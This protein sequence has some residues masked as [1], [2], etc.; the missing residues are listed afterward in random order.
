MVCFEDLVQLSLS[1]DRNEYHEI[2]ELTN[3]SKDMAAILDYFNN[4]N[5]KKKYRYNTNLE[6]ELLYYFQQISEHDKKEIIEFTKIKVKNKK[7]N[8]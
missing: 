4:P 3:S 8:C 7:K 1:I 6:K 5:N 2:P